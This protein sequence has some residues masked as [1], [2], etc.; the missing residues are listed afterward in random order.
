[1]SVRSRYPRLQPCDLGNP[2]RYVCTVLVRVCTGPSYGYRRGYNHVV[3]QKNPTGWPS[4]AELVAAHKRAEAI[5][6]AMHAGED[7][8]PLRHPLAG[9][10]FRYS[11][12][13]PPFALQFARSP[14]GKLICTGLL[15]GWQIDAIGDASKVPA[16][17]RTELTARALR[18]IKLPEVLKNLEPLSKDEEAGGPRSRKRS[19]VKEFDD[20]TPLPNWLDQNVPIRHPGPKGHTDE[21]YKMVVELYRTALIAEP[22]APM[23]W[24]AKQL[25]KSEMTAYR[26]LDEAAERGFLPKRQKVARSP[27]LPTNKPRQLNQP[28]KRKGSR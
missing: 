15:I 4:E 28:P 5:V 1:M 16:E 6:D 2:H 23:K 8:A 24:L 17:K 25:G 7:P 10:F 12:H 14:N 21:H 11:R 18:R 19:S 22:K 20:V 3:P 26:W 9:P 27:R 13:D